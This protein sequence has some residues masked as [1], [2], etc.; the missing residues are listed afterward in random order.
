[1]PWGSG[2]R[3]AIAERPLSL[4]RRRRN[5]RGAP[6]D[7]PVAQP[8]W[9]VPALRG[10]GDQ[11]FEHIVLHDQHSVLPTKT[12]QFPSARPPPCT[13]AGP[14]LP[15]PAIQFAKVPSLIGGPQDP[16][17]TTSRGHRLWLSASGDQH[18]YC[19]HRVGS[20]APADG[21]ASRA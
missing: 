14:G 18:R 16:V 17:T 21:D 2:G 4:E 13:I 1:M 11:A 19:E 8:P 7:C 9:S 15:I 5:P 20:T 6:P 12:S 3:A 10:A